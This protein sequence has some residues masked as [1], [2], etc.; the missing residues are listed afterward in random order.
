MTAF[1]LFLSLLGFGIVTLVMR[2]SW[3]GIQPAWQRAWQ[4]R[5]WIGVAI[6]LIVGGAL[7]S[8]ITLSDS[9]PESWK[10]FGGW[11]LWTTLFTA[12]CIGLMIWFSGW[13]PTAGTSGVSLTPALKAVNWSNVG[14]FFG[15]AML[16][17]IVGWLD[18]QRPH[19]VVARGTINRTKVLARTT[20]WSEPIFV[21]FSRI[22][23][24]QDGTKCVLIAPNGDF[25]NAIKDC[26]QEPEPRLS[27]VEYFQVRSAER[28]DVKFW[29]W[30]K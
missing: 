20:D 5:R 30:F 25:R 4:N 9:T 28:H 18:S 15:I 1:G 2:G 24:A 29:W 19:Y 12:S 6:L 14:W 17:I 7:I 3:G 10:D 11:R 22:G 16:L 27:K 26:G 21:N 13:R 23:W 8:S